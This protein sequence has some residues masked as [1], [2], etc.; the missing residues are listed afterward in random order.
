MSD[1]WSEKTGQGWAMSTVGEGS[2]GRP[3]RGGGGSLSLRHRLR[4]CGFPWSGLLPGPWSPSV[5]INEGR[6][7]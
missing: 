5:V 7:T 1:R 2:R 3:A 4:C 6:A